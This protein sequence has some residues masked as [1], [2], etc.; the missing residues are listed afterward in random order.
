M[1]KD[2]TC[3]PVSAWEETVVMPTYVPPPPDPNPMYLERR[4]NQGTSGRVYPIPLTDRLSNEKEERPYQALFLENDY[5]KLMILP[6]IGG[7]IHVGLDKT[8]GYNFFYRQHVVKPALIGLFG[9]WISGGV[10]F[11]WPQHHRPST[12]M[13]VDYWIEEENDGSRTAWL[14]EHEPMDRMK[15]MIGICLH[16]DKGY[17]EFKVQLYNRTPFPQTFLWWVNAAVHVHPGYQV[18]FPP[19]VTGVTDHSKRAMEH[20]PIAR[21]SYYGVDYSDGVDISWYKHIPVPSSYFALGSSY[22]FFGGYDHTHDAGVIHVANHHIS[23]GKKMFTW[24]TAE[25]GQAWERNLTD[26][27]GPYIELMAGVYTDNQPDFS[28]LQPYE[29]KTFRQYWYPVQRI[30]PARNANR[31]A[32]V[33]LEQGTDSVRV[34]VYAT[35]VLPAAMV[36]LTAGEQTLLEAEVDLGPG[37]PFVGRVALPE[38]AVETDLVLRLRDSAGREVIRYAPQPVP[39]EPL[40]EPAAPPAPPAEIESLEGL[41][42]A[43]VHLEQY[44]HP[45]I[46]PEPF[47]EEA[48]RR[49][50][51]DA[52]CNNALGLVHLRRGSIAPAEAHFRRAIATLTQRNP[53]P[54]DGEPYYN[55][56]LALK[57]AG[58][59]DEAYDALYKAIWSYAWQAAGYYALA[60]IDGQRGD[61][62]RA[63]EHLDH[64]LRTNTMNAKARDLKAAVLRRLG[65]YDEARS[66]LDE[67]IALD[68]LDFWARSERLLLCWAEREAAAAGRG[69]DELA[70]MLAGH[71]AFVR[72]LGLHEAETWA[73]HTQED[74]E[75][76]ADLMREDEGDLQV[77]TYLDVA[78]DYADAGLWAEASELLGRLEDA[79]GEEEPAHAMLLYTLG[80]F[81]C[82]QGLEGE[83][84]AYYERAA[85]QPTGY[86][87]PARLQE[88]EILRHVLSVRP[89]DGKAH[90]YLGNLLYDKRHYDEAMA[91]WEAACRLLPGFSI[92]WRN[93]GV[94]YYNVC[95]DPKA[96]RAHYLKAFEVNPHD[97]RLLSELDQLLRRLGDPPDERLARLEA[98][99]DLI[100]QRDDLVVA[101]AALYTQL[102]QPERALA[103]IMARRFHPWEG[104]EGG[105]LQ[106]YVAA[107]VALGKQALAEG[108]AAEALAHF[109]AARSYP[110]NLGE[111]R[112]PLAPETD[113]LYYVGLAREALGDA[114]GAQAA[115]EQAAGPQRWL[116]EM[117]CYQALAMRKLGQKDAA[118]E[119][120]EALLDH[121]TQELEGARRAGFA[122]SVPSLVFFE[123]EEDLR[124]RQIRYTYQ[125]GLA[126]SGLGQAAEA[127]A[128]FEEVLALD[129]FHAGAREGL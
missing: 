80:F 128:A 105:V 44:R 16:P 99:L 50:P 6:Q 76:L 5:L 32:A 57:Y 78:F 122:T 117:T 67:T 25:F 69:P 35:E 96:A 31:R 68:P 81:A 12:F 47:W 28:W 22:D 74:L 61:F 41:Y 93:L 37:Q 83:G 84:Q 111:G 21:G 27:D 11:N 123:S 70:N 104:G 10:E 49:D 43:G 51:D 120:L 58:R 121:A 2:V 64:S 127:R 14:S 13:P 112:H 100:E 63:L 24:G 119:R 82:Q 108:C 7:R 66:L 26:A 29:V 77:Q 71:G 62:E 90:Y 75:E 85:E 46:D 86:V 89:K 107:H 103:I 52:R 53:N 129:P 19:D 126:R 45:T 97:A 125:I 55:L 110:E 73:L 20:F 54:R 23:P 38:G 48:L 98:H 30:G 18:V 36:T 106:Q 8:N 4:V 101:R 42:L 109:E 34:G 15:G 39:D 1:D 3:G 124:R 113:L 118:R 79:R 87:F 72:R 92:P 40:P 56:G 88:L 95:R 94:A 65:R 102:G 91:H 116:S 33:S 17:V 115:F 114:E 60:E 59:L 9:S